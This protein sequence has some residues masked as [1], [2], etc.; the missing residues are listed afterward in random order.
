MV[1][2]AKPRTLTAIPD[3]RT[4]WD[5]PLIDQCSCSKCGW[6]GPVSTCATGKDQDGWESPV[7]TYHICPICE[8]C[9]DDGCIEHY[10]SSI[11]SY[12]SEVAE[13][14]TG[15]G[16]HD[17]CEESVLSYGKHHSLECKKLRG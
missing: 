6:S 13:G 3:K 8:L 16:L 12:F 7:Y 2:M 17:C 11:A 9:G 5:N 4:S 10:S 1:T 15:G 14:S